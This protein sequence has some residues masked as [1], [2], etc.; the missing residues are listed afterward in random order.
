MKA[1]VH[2]NKIIYTYYLGDSGYMLRPWLIIPVEN[3]QTIEE[4][5]FN[6]THKRAKC[7]I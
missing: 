5:R 6:E 1:K 2:L 3:P 7:F 4:G